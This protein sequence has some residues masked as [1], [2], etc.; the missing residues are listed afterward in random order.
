MT[1]KADLMSYAHDVV[2]SQAVAKAVPMATAGVGFSTAIGWI[3][4]GFAIVAVPIGVM[5][6]IAMWRKTTIETKEAELRVKVLERKL[7]E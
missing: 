7:S 2:T 4:Q 1:S 5:A 3:T 6:T